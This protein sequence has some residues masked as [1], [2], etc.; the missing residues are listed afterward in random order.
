MSK[1]AP[2]AP[3]PRT[4][5]AEALLRAFAEAREE[6]LGTL[7]GHPSE[8]LKTAHAGQHDIGQQQ[9]DAAWIRLTKTQSI[10]AARRLQYYV[11][12][13]VEHPAGHLPHRRLVLH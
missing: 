8:N 10:L 4:K 6:L 11:T 7:A 12:C 1:A 5:P 13:L 2:V 3:Q 9:I